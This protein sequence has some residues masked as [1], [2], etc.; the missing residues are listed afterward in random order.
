[1]KYSFPITV[2]MRAMLPSVNKTFLSVEDN[3]KILSGGESL[4]FTCQAPIM[5]FNVDTALPLS[6]DQ[7]TLVQ[8]TLMPILLGKFPN[9][10]I[11]VEEPTVF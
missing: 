10:D 4:K 7:I 8:T 3:F 2:N 5:H 6:R 11:K 1:M 9:C